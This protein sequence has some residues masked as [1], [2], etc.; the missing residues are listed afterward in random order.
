MRLTRTQGVATE[1]WRELRDFVGHPLWDRFCDMLAEVEAHALRGLAT[2]EL[3]RSPSLRLRSDEHLRG[4]IEAVRAVRTL[5]TDME[6]WD[7]E[8][9]EAEQAALPAVPVPTDP[10]EVE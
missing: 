2:P 9:R 3:M 5:A 4:T 6:L 8:Q 10:W 1:T 7:A